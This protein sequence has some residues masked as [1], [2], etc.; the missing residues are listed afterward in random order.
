MGVLALS[1]FGRLQE[2]DGQLR[3]ASETYRRALHL[4]GH[5]PG[6]TACEAYVGLARISY[7]WNDLDLA[8]EYGLLSVQLARQLE[9]VSFVSCE[10]FLARLKVARGDTT[11]AL[12]MLAQTEQDARERQF[13]S[14]MPEIAALQALASLRKGDLE[15]AAHLVES[16]DLLMSRARVYLAQGEPAKAL[17]VLERFRQQVEAKGWA[18]ELLR[19][20]VVQAVA[21]EANGEHQEA[22][23]LVYEALAQGEAEGFV[24]TF[25]DEGSLMAKLL[26]DANAAGMRTSYTGRLLDAFA[27]EGRNSKPVPE[28]QL[29]RSSP[30]LI[31]PLSRREL[32][33]LHL[34]AEGLSNKEI[35]ER[36]YLSLATIKGHNRVVFRKL[37]VQ[38]RTEAIARG[39]ELGLL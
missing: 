33:V 16:H 24:R 27:A 28:T 37:Q 12:A 14:R 9:I 32:E 31:E 34:V 6:P 20:L 26:S 17:V 15:K 38:R 39:R 35:S 18:D 21:R 4:V 8:E 23:Q 13:L 2:L 10:L 3:L 1:S 7:E 29:V 5:P 22:L 19:V 11:N 36:L 25:V 30:A